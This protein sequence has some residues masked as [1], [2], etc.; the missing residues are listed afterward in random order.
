MM[1]DDMIDKE[2]L[3]D[4]VIQLL[5]CADDSGLIAWK[6]ERNATSSRVTRCGSLGGTVCV[7]ITWSTVGFCGYEIRVNRGEFDALKGDPSAARVSRILDGLERREQE[8]AEQSRRKSAV[9][10]RDDL[11]KALSTGGYRK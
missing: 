4:E 11:E 5:E 8:L 2:A 3:R 1:D 10:A 6:K 7:E 9:Q